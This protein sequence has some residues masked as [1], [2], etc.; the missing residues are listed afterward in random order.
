[1]KKHI[2]Y[3]TINT[4]NRKIYVGVHETSDPHKFDGYLGCGVYIGTT[5][6]KNTAFKRAV[7]KY[8]YDK[9]ERITLGIFDTAEEAYF[10][11]SII[12]TEA[13]IQRHDTY[14]LALGGQ[15]GRRY[16]KTILQYSM[17]GKFI[18]KWDSLIDVITYF[19]KKT[20]SALSKALAKARVSYLNYQWLYYS[21][22]FPTVIAPIE[23][24]LVDKIYQYSLK[25]DFIKEFVSAYAAAKSL[26]D[27]SD[28]TNTIISNRARIIKSATHTRDK[29]ANFQWR[30]FIDFVPLNI[31]VY[32]DNKTVYQMDFEFNIIKVWKSKAEAEKLAFKDLSRCLNG[33]A[34]S[35]HG[36][37]W[38]YK[39]DYEQIRS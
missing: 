15:Y 23:T 19:N 5:P 9:F 10:E 38:C 4:V 16:T 27:I 11:E 12:V 1:M 30:K 14:N 32:V 21:D 28:R 20:S 17:S 3:I 31:E 8:G 36:F 2:V 33:K 25:G 26:T 22:D 24:K 29:Y 39:K 6:S 13:F 34:K 7:R 35:A 18:K 37:I